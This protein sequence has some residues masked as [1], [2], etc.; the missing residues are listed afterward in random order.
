MSAWS[1]SSVPVWSGRGTGAG[2]RPSGF[3]LLEVMIA[4]SLLAIALTTLFGS[5]SQS[6]SL[7][8]TVKFDSQA[9]FLAQMKMAE[10]TTA[11]D[12]VSADSGDFGEDFPGFHWQVEAED[13]KLDGSESLGKLAEKLQQLTLTVSW[14][15]GERFVYPLQ[16]IVLKGSKP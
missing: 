14:G 2:R 9:P 13:V 12:P 7:A 4:I 16:A 1:K 10:L 8:A 5:Q 11:S 6:V 15:D 3:T